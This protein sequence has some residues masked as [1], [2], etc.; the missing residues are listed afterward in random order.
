MV[1][2]MISFLVFEFN[3]SEQ[4]QA[5]FLLVSPA[6]IDRKLRKHKERYL[7]KSIHTN[8][9]GS[10]LKSHILVR[11][12]FDRNEKKPGYLELDTVSHCGALASG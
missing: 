7:L 8:K 5:L 11:V 12:C 2:G 1:K 6:T 10:L 3:L 9:T 4:L